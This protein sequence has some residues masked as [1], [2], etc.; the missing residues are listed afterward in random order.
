MTVSLSYTCRL[1]SSD[2]YNEL[3]ETYPNYL[4]LYVARL[5][6]LDAEKV[7]R[8]RFYSESLILFAVLD[9]VCLWNKGAVF[10][11][12][13]CRLKTCHLRL[14]VLLSYFH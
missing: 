2:I 8:V 13:S 11:F 1:D 7:G 14:N 3:K 6:Q 9:E 12:S 4:P 5:H 10:V